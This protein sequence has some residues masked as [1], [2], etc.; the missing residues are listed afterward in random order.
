MS[1]IS[2]AD[3]I[4]ESRDTSNY[5]ILVSFDFEVRSKSDTEN[6]ANFEITTLG[7]WSGIR[8]HRPISDEQA[9]VLGDEKADENTAAEDAEAGNDRPQCSIER[10]GNDPTEDRPANRL[11]R[12][13]NR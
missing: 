8:S 10:L 1:S 6:H 3:P 7:D 12:A 4:S 11:H 13:K 9:A 5:L 2:A